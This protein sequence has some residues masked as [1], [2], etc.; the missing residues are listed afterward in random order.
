MA[1]SG[2]PTNEIIKLLAS[3]VQRLTNIVE[4]SH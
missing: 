1:G 3:E 4:G 2:V